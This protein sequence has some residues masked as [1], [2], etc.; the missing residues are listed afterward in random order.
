MEIF[1]LENEAQVKEFVQK[2][3]QSGHNEQIRWNID[4]NNKRIIFENASN[5]KP[6]INSS[7]LLRKALRYAH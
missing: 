3:S 2:V 5:Q 7:D 1:Q 4:N 6:S